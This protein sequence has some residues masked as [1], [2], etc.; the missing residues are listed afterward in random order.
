MDWTESQSDHKAGGVG[1]EIKSGKVNYRRAN[2]ADVEILVSYR[3]RFL[4]ELGTRTGHHLDSAKTEVLRKALQEYF[5]RAI[6]SEDFVALLAEYEGEIIGTGAMVVWRRP[7]R[8]GGLESGKAGYI[9]NLYT[10]PK[11]RRKGVCTQL[12]NTLIE[13]AKSLRL[14]Y[15][16]L[17]ASREGIRMYKR[18][19]FV[20]PDEPELELGLG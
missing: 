10:I 1:L 8:Y 6:S 17:H 14:K 19:G 3:I 20:E 16:H 15:L 13:E 9:L 5:A 7:P 4:N 11:A 18:A 12:L 2:V